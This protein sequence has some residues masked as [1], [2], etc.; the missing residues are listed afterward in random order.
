MKVSFHKNFKKSYK[1]HPKK[2]RDQFDKRLKLFLDD[3]YNILLNNHALHDDWLGFRSINVTGDFRAI[4]KHLN[5]N[6]VELV[7]IDTHNNLY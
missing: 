1:R 6:L 4:F 5:E 2:I 7:E 3:P